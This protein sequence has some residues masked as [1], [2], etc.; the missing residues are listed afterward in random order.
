MIFSKLFGGTK[1]KSAGP[2]HIQSALVETMHRDPSLDGCWVSRAIPVALFDGALLTVNYTDYYPD[3][4]P[5]ALA[6][7]DAALGHFL[8]LDI[9]IRDLAT[10]HVHKA[11]CDSI[12]SADWDGKDELEAAT[13]TPTAVWNHVHPKQVYVSRR[14]YDENED[15]YVCVECSCDWDPEHGLQLVYRQG[16]QLTRVSGNDG[17]MT[18]ADA[19]NIPDENDAM[20]SA[21]KG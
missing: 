9:K 11:C 12:N 8:K 10:P 17:H 20:L 16:K 1:A 6:D 15:L 13:R 21:W 3:K 7:Y 14:M 5:D 2:Q 19:L 4:N 18:D